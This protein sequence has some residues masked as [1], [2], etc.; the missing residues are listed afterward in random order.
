MILKKKFLWSNRE[1]L[2]LVPRREQLHIIHLAW[3]QKI[4]RKYEV[5]DNFRERIREVIRRLIRKERKNK[6]GYRKRVLIKLIEK[7]K[8]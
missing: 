7:Q 5:Q 1:L 4:S 6:V 8:K 2:L 3:T